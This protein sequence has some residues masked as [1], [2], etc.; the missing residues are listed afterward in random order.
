MNY[1]VWLHDDGHQTLGED[2]VSLGAGDDG[3][4]GGALAEE[5]HDALAL[6]DGSLPLY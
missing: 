3:L 4:L 1:L 6:T 5:L 2:E